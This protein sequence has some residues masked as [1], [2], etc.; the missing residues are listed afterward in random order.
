MMDRKKWFL[1]L[2]W[3]LFCVALLS[4][5]AYGQ[6]EVNAARVLKVYPIGKIVKK[7]GR[8][9]VVIEKKFEPGLL[10]M[11]GLSSVTVIYW[12]DRIDTSA[13]RSILQ[14]HPRRSM[15]NPLTGVFVA[16]SPVRPNLIGLSR[17]K[18]ISVQGNI[19]EIDDID[20]FSGSPVID[21]KS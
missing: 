6:A 5:G 4:P 14:A 7:D 8:T 16:H 2:I 18:I 13:K 3:A 11:D 21:L 15:E 17:C 12:F 19:M 9:L 1:L 20:A 10:G